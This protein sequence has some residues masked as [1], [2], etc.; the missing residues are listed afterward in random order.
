MD[1]CQYDLPVSVLCHAGDLPDDIFRP[2]AADS[3]S[4]IG[5]NAVR[6]ELIASVLNFNIGTSVLRRLFQSHFFVFCSMVN[7]YNSSVMQSL[8]HTMPGIFC[9]LRHRIFLFQIL[10]IFLQ[11]GRQVLLAVVADRQIDAGILLHIFPSG[12]HVASHSHHQCRRIFL[13]RTMKHLSAFPVCNIG[14][15]AGIYNIN[16]CGFIKWY[17]SIT[18]FL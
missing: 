10:Q 6:A 4:G 16:I 3:A 12:L 18:F 1:T 13:L 5:D 14:N 7:V 9:I 17:N 15:C 8:V 2:A 11:N